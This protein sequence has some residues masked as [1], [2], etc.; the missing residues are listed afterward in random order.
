MSAFKTIANLTKA[1]QFYQSE[2]ERL[3]KAN[4]CQLALY[5]EWNRQDVL[6]I[7]RLKTEI[8]QLKYQIKQ[9]SETPV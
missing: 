9:L 4:E 3:K 7:A 8:K 1:N 6:F 5:E 2:I